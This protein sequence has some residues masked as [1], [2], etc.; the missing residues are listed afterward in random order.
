MQHIV[1]TYPAQALTGCIVVIQSIILRLSGIECLASG[2]MGKHLIAGGGS[3]QRQIVRQY[4]GLVGVDA[5]PG[6]VGIH[7]GAM[8]NFR[9]GSGEEQQH[10]QEQSG[11]GLH[12]KHLLD[13]IAAFIIHDRL[14]VVKEGRFFK[15]M[16]YICNLFKHSS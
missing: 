14:H 15:K 1:C 4:D 3:V 11:D 12:R 9:I 5:D 6:K 16:I 13:A 10:G 2:Q 7:L 8:K